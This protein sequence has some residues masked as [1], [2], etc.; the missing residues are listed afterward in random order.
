MTEDGRTFVREIPEDEI[1]EPPVQ[2]VLENPN[3][4]PDPSIPPPSGGCYV[5]GCS[6]QIC[7]EDPAAV[8]T[9]EWREAYACYRTAKC[10]RQP[11][12]QCG[13]TDTPELRSCL[14]NA[15]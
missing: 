4:T 9:C 11:S 13:W 8:S 10:E 2:D 1:P 7:S 3:P 12:G 14:A 15:R 6:G 5:G